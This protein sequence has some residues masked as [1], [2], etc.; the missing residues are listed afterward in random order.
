MWINLNKEECDCV[1]EEIDPRL[2]KL[3]DFFPKE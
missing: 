3:K 2:E 1:L